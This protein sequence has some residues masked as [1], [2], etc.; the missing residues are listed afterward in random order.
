MK[1]IKLGEVLDVKRGTSLSGKFYEN[2]G[3]Y[4][5]LTLGNFTYPECGW[6]DNTS[7]DDLYYSGDFKNEYLLKKDDIITPLTEQVRGLLGNT[8]RIPESDLYIQSGDIG[9]I[10]PFEKLLDK[11]F[12]YYLV[13]SPIVKK[14]L[15][16]ASQQTKIR[17]TSP[18]AIK[19]CIAFIP[20]LASQKKIANLL[21]SLNK[22]ISTN[23]CIISELE[24]LAK[25][26][27]DYWFLQFEFPN[28]DGKPYKSSG[29]K[30]VWNEELKR[31]IPEKWSVKRYSDITNT[32]TGKEDANFATE[33]GKY[34]YFT[35]GSN[36]LKCDEYKFDGKA[37]L[38]AGNG[39]FNVKYY[40]GKFNAYQR[41]YVLM[42]DEKYIGILYQASKRKIECFKKG[43]NGS[44]V[45]FITKGDIDNIELTIP[46]DDKLFDPFNSILNFI[47]HN[48]IENFKLAS[49]RDFLLP[50]LMNGQV[51]F[52]D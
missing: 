15:D 50:M 46:D 11:N 14:Q 33:N 37:I 28:E 9:K 44:I 23:N 40:D 25:T 36:I 43:S 19:N 42:P 16:A 30:M 27:Y 20:E 47:H 10:I 3:K 41:T 13:S 39:D 48:K 32:T 29:G 21:D 18:D 4:I 24:S 5:R 35:C 52:K 8:A 34:A 2:S 6:K 38:I 45:K 7:K 1:E 31:E 49:L 12:A 26:I 22:K 17:H 51:T